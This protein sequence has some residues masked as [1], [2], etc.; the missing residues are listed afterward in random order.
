MLEARA[1]FVEHLAG[2]VEDREAA[3]AAFVV[4]FVG[5][6]D[7]VIVEPLHRI[8]LALAAR[9]LVLEGDGAVALD[10]DILEVDG[11]SR[12]VR[13][14]RRSLAVDDDDVVVLLQRQRNLVL[15]VEGDEFRLR[16]FASDFGKTRQRHALQ[17]A[18]IGNAVLQGQDHQ[19][20]GRHL[21]DLAVVHFL[22]AL[23][24]NGDGRKRTVLV[25]GNRVRLTA[26]IAGRIH[27][28]R[29]QVDDCQKTGRLDEAFARVDRN[30]RLG[31]GNGNGGRLTVERDCAGCLRRLGIGDVD[32]AD[33]LA[34]AVGVDQRIAVFAGRDDLGGRRRFA[35]VTIRQ[36]VGNGKGRNTIEYR[37]SRRRKCHRSKKD[38]RERGHARSN[39]H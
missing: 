7:A 38:G 39:D 35:R 37:F 28:L 1:R 26:E 23:V 32:Q 9:L 6:D 36:I 11:A 22:V 27:L 2:G 30:E 5:N 17:R 19:I 16:I 20:A 29:R 31:A 15:A 33:A 3:R 24:F 4:T 21:R 14:H 8:G 18:A 13:L 25:D 34:R 12:E 10:V